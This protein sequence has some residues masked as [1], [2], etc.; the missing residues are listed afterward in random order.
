MPSSKPILG[1]NDLQSQ[2]P[3]I[4]KEWHS[5]KNGDL[6]P[7]EVTKGSGKKVWWQCNKH[8]DHEWV[9]GI[10]SRT[11]QNLGCPICSGKRVHEGF[12]DLQTLAPEL[13]KEWHPTKNDNLNPTNLTKGSK[14]K[15]WWQCNKYP[16]HEWESVISHRLQG[17]GCPICSG[18][19]VLIGFNDLQTLEPELSK[20]WHPTKN[21]DL[22]ASEF[23]SG[24]NK[25]VWWQCSNY[26]DHQWDAV[27]GAR[28]GQDQGCPICI[29]HKVL[30]GF[31]DLQTLEPELSKEWH[32]TKNG[33]LK[34]NEVT[35][36]S[37][38]K[39]WWQCSN[40]PDHQ[41]DAVIGSRT[42][43]GA[44]CPI[45]A[46]K[47]VLVGF[48]DLNTTNPDIANQWHPTKNGDL[49]PNEVTKGSNKKVWWQC[50]NYPD[51]QWDAVIGSR[52]NLGAEC[53]ICAGKKVLVGFNDLNTTDPD[54]ANQWHP[55]KNGDLK[56]NEVTKGSNKKVWWQCSNYPDHQWM[57][58]VC[59]RGINNSGC[60]ICDGKKV[61]VGFNDL[62]T[63]DP[64]IAMQW[65]P[66]KN[67]DL[68]PIQVLRF[69]IKKV[70]WQCNKH[71]DHEWETNISKRTVG[72][73]C[74]ICIGHKVLDGFNDLQ[75]LEPELS[76]EWHP[77]KNGDL[78]PN[79]VTK[80]SG[81]KVWWQC[82]NYPDHQWDASICDR[83]NGVGCPSCA[84]YGFDP[85]KDAWFYLMERPG[86]QQLGISNVLVDRLRTH[87]SNGWSLI[88]HTS[89]PSKG[90]KV[91]DTEN[92]FK[93]WLKKEIGLM[94]GSTENWSTT[95]MEVQSLAELK[96]RSGIETDLF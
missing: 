71:P 18:H 63:T 3:D 17:Q 42:N 22:K 13:S 95:K 89:V 27:I 12:N 60:P 56:P 75:T 10:G 44:E 80:G 41:W 4:A 74:P 54:I 77:T 84:K 33:D 82:S 73:G 58:N 85:E 9:A 76:K 59:N 32:P 29:G 52:T 72:Q 49:K 5:S 30:D 67:G 23:T 21:G 87:E 66:T 19:R 46:G 53:P 70:W 91:L 93:K 51:H 83:S 57:I 34:P 50:S 38:K 36:G 88:E 31:N 7:N 55:T 47:K 25:K 8:P 94:E 62:N 96:A 26:P 65:H 69:S 86:E 45:C 79:E 78:K 90:Q 81:K 11:G 68:K 1:V 24:S 61:L 20:E 37:R 39:V 35:K 14:Q 64:E 15:V 2:F 6:K 92:A 43:L 16:D 28:T 48:N 40:Y